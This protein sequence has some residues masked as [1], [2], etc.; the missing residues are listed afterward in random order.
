M[1]LLWGFEGREVPQGK[2]GSGVW[3]LVGVVCSE[4]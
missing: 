1:I 4:F 3:E 2:M